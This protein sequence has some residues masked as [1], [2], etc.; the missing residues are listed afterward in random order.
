MASTTN[1]VV[2]SDALLKR[3][4]EIEGLDVTAG[5]G[6]MQHKL[7]FY[8]KQLQN[9]AQRHTQ[10]A[11][12]IEELLK[13][14]DTRAAMLLAHSLKGVAATLGIEHIRHIAA[15]IEAILKQEIS[16]PLNEVALPLKQLNQALIA[17]SAKF[18]VLVSAPEPIQEKLSVDYSANQLNAVVIEMRSLLVTGNIKSIA[19]LEE[20]RQAF[21]LILGNAAFIKLSLHAEKFEFEQA[22]YI[23]QQAQV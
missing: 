2:D 17:F 5:L 15:T 8:F 6:N 14:H 12:H 19:Y 9:F 4:G 13:I 10:E 22:L 1:K 18:Q 11:K 20:H 7:P 16:N 3:L 23:L 21:Q